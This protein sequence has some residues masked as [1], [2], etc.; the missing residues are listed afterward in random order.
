MVQCSTDTSYLSQ[1]STRNCQDSTSRCLLVFLHGEEFVS[2]TVND[3]N[4]DLNKFP[5]SKVRQLEKKMGS[6]KAMAKHI[7]QVVSDPQAAQIHSMHHQH[8]ELPPN[9][10]QRK[11]KKHFKSRQDTTSSIPMRI[12]TS[13]IKIKKNKE[14]QRFGYFALFKT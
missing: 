7:K 5:G 2:K 12:I 6:S 10:F 4:I 9:K 11:Q 13:N 1:V 8:T 14:S 3:S